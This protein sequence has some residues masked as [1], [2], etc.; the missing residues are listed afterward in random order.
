MK[1]EC[2]GRRGDPEWEGN[3]KT[4][5]SHQTPKEIHCR[6]YTN[7][8][9]EESQGN[10]LADSEVKAATRQLLIIGVIT[11]GKPGEVKWPNLTNPEKMYQEDS[12][13]SKAGKL[14]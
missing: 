2:C 13:K 9:T 4:I 6:A 8:A 5:G 14:C 12:S 7:N 1:P 11:T 10:A 3:K